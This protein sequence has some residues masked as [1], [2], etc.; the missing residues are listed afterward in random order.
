ME[1]VQLVGID[2][3]KGGEK[4][5]LRKFANEYVEKISKLVNNEVS[6]KLHVKVR[7]KTGKQHQYVIKVMVRSAAGNFESEESDWELKRTL[8]K[9]FT[10]IENQV[11]HKFRE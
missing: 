3:L 4:H 11:K 1:P 2:D 5:L 6:I 9:V 8:H 7:S 10:N